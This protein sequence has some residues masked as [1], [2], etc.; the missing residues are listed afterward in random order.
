MRSFILSAIV[1]IGFPLASQCTINPRDEPTKPTKPARPISVPG[2]TRATARF[3]PYKLEPNSNGGFKEGYGLNVESAVNITM[4]CQGCTYTYFR[5]DMV[6]KNGTSANTGNG[7]YIHSI[8]IL[9]V[10]T[11]NFN[12]DSLYQMLIMVLSNLTK[13]LDLTSFG[14]K[15]LYTIANDRLPISFQNAGAYLP[16]NSS[17]VLMTQLQNLEKNVKEVY[18][19]LDYDYLPGKP[20]GYVDIIPILQNPL[21]AGPIN[22][23]GLWE[24]TSNPYQSNQDAQILMIYGTIHDGG[25]HTEIMINGKVVCDSVA[26][27]QDMKIPGQY[28]YIKHDDGGNSH[29]M[30]FGKCLE[31]GQIKKGDFITTKFYFDFDKRPSIQMGN[32]KLDELISTSMT[33]LGVP[34]KKK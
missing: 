18:I 10:P 33:F 6:Y 20:E 13:P 7:A 1:S 21:F 22:R 16:T 19:D 29:I 17:V 3:G 27:Y 24:A 31:P 23:T 2:A 32:G 4:P 15:T 8:R 34:M 12:I 26:Y 5:G 25:I 9:S 30:A 28:S 11:E 14:F